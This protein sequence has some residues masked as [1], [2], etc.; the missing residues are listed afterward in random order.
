MEAGEDW[1]GKDADGYD[2]LVTVDFRVTCD[3]CGRVWIFTVDELTAKYDDL[4]NLGRPAVAGVHVGLEV[5]AAGA[6]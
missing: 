1:L 4:S 5:G 3:R 2:K 6:V